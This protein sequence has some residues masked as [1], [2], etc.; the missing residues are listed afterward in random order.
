MKIPTAKRLSA[1]RPSAILGLVQKAKAMAAVGHPVI[2]LGIGE[3]D[4]STPEH[5]QS[6]AIAAMSNGKTKYTPVPGTVETREAIVRKLARENGLTYT[7]DEIT[8][9]GGAK[10]AIYNAFMATLSAGDEVIIPAPYWSSYPDMVAMAD[11]TPILVDCPQEQRFLLEPEQLEAAITPQT[12][13]LMLNSP[14][15]PTGNIYRP[16]DLK[17]IAAV[18][19]KHPHVMVLSDDIYEHLMFDGLT[20]CSILNEAPEL[21]DRVLVVNGVSKVFA[22]TGWRLGYAAGPKDLIQAMNTVQGQSTSHASSIAQAATIEA[23][24]GPTDFMVERA[25]SFQM[26]RDL[27]VDTLGQLKGIDMLRPEGAFYVFPKVAGLI[28]KVTSTGKTL[29]SDVDVCDWLLDDHHVSCVPGSAFGLSPHIRI[30]TASSKENLQEA[31]R[32]ITFAVTSLG[33]G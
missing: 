24:D 17:A 7:A 32:R 21:R 5:I 30:S 29:L 23:L 27:V 3:P 22:M 11:G 19:L 33:G 8:V 28:G 14:S 26:R 31:C 9:T 12:R 20:F 6:A 2:D 15:N 10:Q 18:L 16:E 25:T 1:V 4:F 13:W